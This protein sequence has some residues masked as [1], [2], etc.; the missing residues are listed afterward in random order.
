M[1]TKLLAFGLAAI[2]ALPALAKATPKGITGDYMEFRSADVY[3]GPCF[4]NGEMGLDGKNALLAWHVRQGAWNGV[5][6]AGLSVVAVVRASNTLG[7]RFGSPLPARSVVI[8]DR[9][10]TAAQR[11]ALVNFAKAQAGSLLE[12][13]IAVESQPISFEVNETDRGYATLKAGNLVELIT[14]A[15]EMKDMFCHNE[16]IYYQPLVG[17]LQHAVPAVELES[18]YTGNHLNVTWNDSG[19]RS[20]FVAA[21]DAQ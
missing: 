9:Q 21:F 13:V 19:R 10:A 18:A 2:L 1:K 15:V 3:T 16:E 11:T 6:L 12:N 8:V 14:R 17:H 7:D 4:A 5:S 20:S